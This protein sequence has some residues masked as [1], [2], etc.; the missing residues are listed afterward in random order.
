MK[1]RTGESPP[2]LWG[3]EMQY[4]EFVR[5]FQERTGIQDQQEAV[6]VIGATLETLGECISQTELADMASQLPTELSGY[7]WRV[8][9]EEYF[10][11]REFYRRVARRADITV[12]EATERARDVVAVLQEAV[13]KGE[14]ADIREELPEDYEEL[15][16]ARAVQ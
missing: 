14:I 16:R 11:I 9:Q 10:S 2:R 6:R 12:P 4:A 1:L 3:I 13:S 7:L 5:R 8:Q 15:F